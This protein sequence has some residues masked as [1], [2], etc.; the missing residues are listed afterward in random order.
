MRHALIE[1][2]SAV[3]APFSQEFTKKMIKI[4]THENVS[5]AV[6]SSYFSQAGGFE[7]LKKFVTSV[8]SQS[9]EKKEIFD[10]EAL[11]KSARSYV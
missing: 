5:K 2:L 11:L 7:P 8:N 4:L 9:L 3:E 10:L 1:L 6:C